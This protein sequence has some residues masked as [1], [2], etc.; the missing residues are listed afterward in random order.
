M[1]RPEIESFPVDVARKLKTYATLQEVK[2]Y[3]A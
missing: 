3:E 2:E 1:N